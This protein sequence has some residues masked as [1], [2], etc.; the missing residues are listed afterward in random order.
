MLTQTHKYNAVKANSAII[1]DYD[2]QTDFSNFDMVLLELKNDNSEFRFR[3]E[4]YN[5]FFDS[6]IKILDLG[7]LSN[8][9]IEDLEDISSSCYQ[10]N[11]PLILI[12]KEINLSTKIYR[13][14]TSKQEKISPVFIDTFVEYTQENK[15]IWD[16]MS[17]YSDFLWHPALIGYQNYLVHPNII[18]ELNNGKF[19]T[20]RLSKLIQNNTNEPYIRLADSLSINMNAIKY[21]DNPAS[22]N[23]Q[24]N[25][26]SARDICKISYLYGLSENSK[27]LG[28][29]NY[30]GEKDI[31]DVSAK[32]V[33]QI[34]WHY[35]DAY[36]YK[37]TTENQTKN[38][39]ILHV[40]LDD[41]QL[42]GK[43]LKFIYNEN[44]KLW[45]FDIGENHKI[46]CNFKDY[47]L[48]RQG[49]LS[50]FV[51]NFLQ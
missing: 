12:S 6:N 18:R 20:I 40:S 28:I 11:I 8:E 32:L 24:P 3:Q 13:T 44:S 37:K 25:G 47:D 34:I 42:K 41:K 50:E 48:A 26:L 1:T 38:E 16:F 31:F 19:E 36:S 9:N 30:D 33:A 10:K 39:K 17:L 15:T 22:Q 45:F 5:F 21:S 14:L 43:S 2:N 4:L 35:I 49:I 29:F 51:E 23:P 27:F 46:P 7:F